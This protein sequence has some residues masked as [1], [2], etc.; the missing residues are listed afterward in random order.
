MVPAEG[1][2]TMS[3]DDAAR[4]SAWEDDGGAVPEAAP[5]EA[6][7]P[8]RAARRRALLVGSVL[9]IAALV[10]VLWLFV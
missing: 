10:L 9:A 4:R 1:G 6:A 8:R 7:I 3:P 2:V 5:P